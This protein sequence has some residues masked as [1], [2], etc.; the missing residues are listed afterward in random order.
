MKWSA[1]CLDLN[2]RFTA[3]LALPLNLNNFKKQMSHLLFF[4]FLDSKFKQD[5]HE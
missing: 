4:F 2:N 5:L 3:S 1:A